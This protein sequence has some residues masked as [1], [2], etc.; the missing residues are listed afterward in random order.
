[1]TLKIGILADD[2]TSAT[3]GASPFV[4]RGLS[5]IVFTEHNQGVLRDAQ[6]ISVNKASRTASASVAAERTRRATEALA[7]ADILYVTVDSTIRGHLSIEVTAALTA[8]GRSVVIFAPAFPDGGR[9][10]EG[11]RQ[12][13]HGVPLEETDFANDP[14]HPVTNSH[15][16]AHFPGFPES[17]VRFIG[18]EELRSLTSGSLTLDDRTLLIVDAVCQS[19]LNHLVKTVRDPRSI[20]WCGSPGLAIALAGSLDILSGNHRSS[21]GLNLFVIGSVNPQSREQCSRLIKAGAALQIVIDAD[22]ASHS[23]E[24][25]AN[26]AIAQFGLSSSGNVILT[27]SKGSP[28]VNPRVI[29]T[30]LGAAARELISAHHFTG[31]FLTGG[32]T[33]ESVLRE[34]GIGALD[35]LGEIEPGIPIGRTTGSDP[36]HI[37]TK[38]G[39]FGSPDVLQKSAD[40]LRGLQL[41]EKK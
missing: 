12:L 15:V 7:D 23:P 18:L 8:S 5:C 3:D 38:A 17:T 20:L 4:E 41:G 37:I 22:L 34:L 24:H 35:L 28:S 14:L 33:A 13:L 39:G 26:D 11:G 27:S 9:T 21:T 29:A 40:V 10:T 1:M 36:I 19:D 32:D 16:R 2:L 31:L 30:A 25:A 6:V